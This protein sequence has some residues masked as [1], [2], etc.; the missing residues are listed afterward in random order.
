MGKKLRKN[1]Y[2]G[3]RKP[4]NNVSNSSSEHSIWNDKKGIIFPDVIG[5]IQRTFTWF[6]TSAPRLLQL[7]IFLLMVLLLA[8]I[9]GFFIN[10]TGNF[11][12]TAGNEYKTGTFSVVTN[13]QLIADMPSNDD[14]NSETI[15][16]NTVDEGNT[17]ILTCGAFFYD[18]E[19]IL[20]NGTR[21]G[22]EEGYYFHD[23]GRCTECDNIIKVYV[24]VGQTERYCDQEVLYPKSYD[25]LTLLGKWTC[26]KTLG[27]CSIPEGYYWR[28][29][30]N[31]LVCDS[32]LCKNEV[33]EDNTVGQLWNLKLKQSGAKIVEEEDANRQD[34]K[35]MI[36]LD[37]E[38]GDINPKFKFFGIEV[39]NY[40][41]WVMLILFSALIWAVYKIKHP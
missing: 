1:S 17:K 37:C 16:A 9:F 18:V 32:P 14:L 35:N 24:G 8:S 39:F 26:G 21:T 27:A 6:L 38:A 36:T 23:S 29:T 28:Q 12:D 4:R 13:I 19:K 34:Y 2:L 25:D 10:G 3:E 7:L 22:L 40:K 11:C 5:A 31:Q 33:G 20:D 15:D 30:D 41:L